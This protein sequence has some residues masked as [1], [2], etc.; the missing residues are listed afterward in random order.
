MISFL[1]MFL[2]Y[3]EDVLYVQ[4]SPSPYLKVARITCYVFFSF[5]KFV[6]MFAQRI[7]EEACFDEDENDGIH[8]EGRI[9]VQAEMQDGETVMFR[10]AQL[11]LSLQPN[12]RCSLSI[13][14]PQHIVGPYEAG[15]G[16][17]H[18][19]EDS[20]VP[21]LTK[22]SF[23]MKS[24]PHSPQGYMLVM[25]QQCWKFRKIPGAMRNIALY[26]MQVKLEPRALCNG[27]VFPKSRDR[28]RLEELRPMG[29]RAFVYGS[30]G[31]RWYSQADV[32][33]F[34]ARRHTS[35]VYS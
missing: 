33:G 35:C 4:S 15:V 10:V 27:V 11:A 12:F 24:V 2:V 34:S 25:T 32:T 3:N 26:D 6:A 29:P 31:G 7:Q 20:L 21:A 28:R 23:V 30:S 9:R 1:L 19:Y 13:K 18:S 17:G 8:Q 5:V 16:Y 14:E 22:A